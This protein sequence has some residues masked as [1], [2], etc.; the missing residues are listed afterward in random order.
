MRQM[1]NSELRIKARTPLLREVAYSKIKE[2]ILNG[3]FQPREFLSESKLIAYLDMSKT[4]IKSAI[5]KLEAEGFVTVAPKQGIV[6]TE[7]SLEKVRDIFDLRIALE[8]YVCEQIAGKLSARQQEQI[9]LNLE[10]S[11]NMALRENEVEFAKIDAEFHLFLSEVCGNKE[12]HRTMTNYQDQL[13]LNALSVLRKNSGR[14]RTSHEDHVGIY[15]SLLTDNPAKS[16]NLM[17][18]H[19]EYGKL[20]L[21]R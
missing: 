15:K 19:L 5:D 16:M 6:V 12:L 3:T 13:Y 9:E 8:S 14:M 21:V 11:E 20:I 4:P 2:A 17:R 1:P 10:R 7:L 18:K